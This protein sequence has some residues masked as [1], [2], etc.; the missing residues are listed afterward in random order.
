M[1]AVAGALSEADAPPEAEEDGCG[2]LSDRLMTELS[3]HRT[4]ALREAL[5]NDP[6]AA[7]LAVLHALAL[8]MFYGSDTVDTCLEI[9][10]KSVPLKTVAGP[11][12]NDTAMAQS[13]QQRHGAWSLR[14][15]RQPEGLW[16]DL[17]DL[18]GDSRA[19]LFAHCVAGTVNALSPSYDRRPRALAHAERLATLTGLDMAEHWTPTVDTYLGR[20]TKAQILDA[21]RE[22]K[23][24]TSAQLI[25]PLKKSDMA[26]EAERLLAG[27]GWLPPVL[28]TPGLTAA[29]PLAGPRAGNGEDGSEAAA[30][31]LPAFLVEGEADAAE[32]LAPYL[33][34]AE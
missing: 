33:A 11:G 16:D 21:V 28:R 13:A 32:A 9:E 1:G 5:A 6:D 17:L 20:V 29:L 14:L 3:A 7:F 31:V 24:A 34:A 8:R 23:G 2:R 22:A 10:A 27:T 4:L 12:L 18:D 15:P 19:A 25:E 26:R 30:A